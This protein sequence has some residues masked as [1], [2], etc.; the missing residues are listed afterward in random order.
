M[1]FKQFKHLLFKNKLIEKQLFVL[2]FII[3]LI[4]GITQ[5]Y[6]LIARR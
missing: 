4:Y 1:F 3:D 2:Q 6:D 5:I